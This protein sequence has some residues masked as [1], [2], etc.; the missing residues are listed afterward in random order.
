MAKARVGL[1]DERLPIE[2]MYKNPLPP[3]NQ[4]FVVEGGKPKIQVDTIFRLNYPN[5]ID[6]NR[7]DSYERTPQMNESMK[8]MVR[9]TEIQ[10]ERC[11]I[12]QMQ[13]N[14]RR[15]QAQQNSCGELQRQA[16][17]KINN[18][19]LLPGKNKTLYGVVII[20]LLH[21]GWITS[22]ALLPSTACQTNFLVSATN[23]PV[24]LYF[25]YW[26]PAFVHLFSILVSFTW[27]YKTLWVISVS[28]GFAA[29]IWQV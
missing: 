1:G 21:L 2:T 10:L 24:A 16:Y 11:N 25:L 15:M 14:G 26:L 23:D 17:T 7:L 6:M 12:M 27:P 4:Y 28:F 18:T 20:S 13:K 8:E 22:M 29:L 5:A 9:Q 19:I 3:Q